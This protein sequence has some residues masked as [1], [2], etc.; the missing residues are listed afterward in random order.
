M[1]GLKKNWRRRKRKE[2]LVKTKTVELSG[3]GMHSGVLANVIVRPTESGGIVF[4][5]NGVKMKAAW[6]NITPSPLRSTLIGRGPNQIQTIEHLMCALYV[7]QIA[8]AEI[9]IDKGEMPILDGSAKEWIKALKKLKTA[10]AAPFLR[11]KR[12]VTAEYKELKIP[13]WLKIFD[14]F[15]GNKKKTAFVRLSPGNGKNRLEISAE[16]DYSAPV[17]GLQKYEFC[18][19]YNDFPKSAEN[20][21]KEVAMTRT[22]GTEGEWKWLKKHGMGNGANGQN[23][24][25]VNRDGTDTLNDLFYKSP[26]EKK[27]ILQAYGY[28]LPKGAKVTRKYFD[29][30]FVRHKILDAVG[31]LY[32]S[33]YRIVGKMEFIKGGGHA[34]NSL[35]LKKLFGDPENY[36]IIVP[37]G[38]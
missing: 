19:D 24:L 18:F 15:R 3:V 33:G 27:R 4:V 14:L 32:A 28:L 26:S 2:M 5:R 9:R 23:V 22:F 1:H 31:D 7:C 13:L 35:A 16:I 6:D 11:I 21:M 20:F 38:R 36:D 12:Q 34:L 25:A 30:E 37:R 10:G 29:D 17:I 8:N